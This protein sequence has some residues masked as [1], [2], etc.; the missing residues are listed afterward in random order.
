M[1]D[2]SSA[3]KCAK[4]FRSSLFGKSFNDIVSLATT[5]ALE[6]TSFLLQHESNPD[7]ICT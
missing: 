1:K 4:I 5:V 3:P 7:A 2:K 6:H